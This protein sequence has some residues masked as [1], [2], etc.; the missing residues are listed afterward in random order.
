MIQT[1]RRELL[2][3]LGASLF[4]A[5]AIVHATSLMK[6]KP[7]KKYG[8]IDWT[9]E[10]Y[11]QVNEIDY[12]PNHPLKGLQQAAGWATGR[13][14]LQNSY[15]TGL[16]IEDGLITSVNIISP[17]IGPIWRVVDK[18]PIENLKA[19]GYQVCDRGH[20]VP[21]IKNLKNDFVWQKIKWRDEPHAFFQ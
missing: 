17:D 20:D 6:I 13:D 7:T 4:A 10:L 18:F 15:I 3:G 5:P 12:I 9:E 1:S 8:P 19:A 14:N 16:N 2:I 11:K 21:Y